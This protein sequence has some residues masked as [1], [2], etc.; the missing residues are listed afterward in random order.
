[1][2]EERPGLR[3]SISFAIT[4]TE[5]AR[6]SLLMAWACGRLADAAV[7]LWLVLICGLVA[8]LVSAVPYLLI[9]FFPRAMAATDAD[10]FRPAARRPSRRWGPSIGWPAF[11]AGLVLV[12]LAR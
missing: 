3:W 7:A 12:G 8:A 2:T 4:F 11:S 10:L 6:V 9:R 1:V 5:F